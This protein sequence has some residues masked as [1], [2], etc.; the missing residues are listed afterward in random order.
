MPQIRQWNNLVEEVMRS[1][2]STSSNELSIGVFVKRFDFNRVE[3]TRIE[4]SALPFLKSESMLLHICG[5]DE[6]EI[7]DK[8]KEVIGKFLEE[9]GLSVDARVSVSEDGEE[10]ARKEYS[11]RINLFVDMGSTNSKW[12]VSNA[13]NDSLL[14]IPVG[15]S[16]SE[17]C[18]E[19]GLDYDKVSAY[20]KGGEEFSRWLEYAVIKFVR[21]IQDEHRANVVNVK[22]SFPRVVDGTRLDFTKISDDVTVDLTA[23]Y[24][25]EGKFEL[26]PEGCAL[27]HMFRESVVELAKACESEKAENERRAKEE[28]E[29]KEHNRGERA[30]V[31]ANE[32]QR[33]QEL[34]EHENKFFIKRWFSKKYH[35]PLYEPEIKD[36]DLGREEFWKAFC[37]TGASGNGKF[38]LLILD[39]G[40]STLDYC[41]V[42]FSGKVVAGSYRAGGSDV[43]IRLA[44]SLGL[45]LKEAEDRKRQLSKAV[46][47]DALM[48]A[49]NAVYREPLGRITKVVQNRTRGLCVVGSGLAMCNRQL[50]KK[51]MEVL[52]IENQMFV[53]SPDIVALFPLE[54]QN[55][56]DWFK[57]FKSIVLHVEEGKDLKHGAPWPSSDVCGGMYFMMM[58]EKK[59]GTV[60]K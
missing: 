25:L 42:P 30:K 53:F 2:F 14:A 9:Y 38:D 31:E 46:E 55:D 4:C 51:V 35:T 59:K 6:I 23:Y 5:G 43:T 27:E 54:K 39:A 28:T 24:G 47:S 40:G 44:E 45:E 26:V 15:K 21:H 50:R 49:T 48:N 41:Y 11:K 18:A 10:L 58:A 12:I 3:V 60:R 19:W 34:R 1:N 20:A 57:A 16:T 13:D 36:E 8:V 29:N 7:E 33:E 17:L 52:H 37:N 56:F 32:K 22:W